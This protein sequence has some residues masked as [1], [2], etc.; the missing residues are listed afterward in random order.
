MSILPLPKSGKIDKIYHIADI[1]IRKGDET[2]NRYEE[3][4][5]IFSKFINQIRK[6]ESES[7]VCIIA[8]DLFHDKIIYGPSGIKLF[9][10]LITGISE[11]MPIYIIS[12]NHDLDP[13]NQFSID[14]I[15]PIINSN[16]WSNVVHL[17][18][19]KH[20][21]AGDIS[22]G[23]VPIKYTIDGNTGLIDPLPDF[24][25]AQK[26]YRINIGL[27][28]GYVQKSIPLSWFPSDY[29]YLILGDL[30]LQIVG[31]GNKIENEI[32]DINSEISIMSKYKKIEGKMLWGY[33]GSIVQQNYGENLLGHGFLV[34][35]LKNETVEGYHINNEY[36]LANI[37]YIDNE[38]CCH[39]SYGLDDR[40]EILEDCIKRNWFPNNIGVRIKGN[41]TDYRE[42][43]DIFKKG[44]ILCKD[45]KVGID[46]IDKSVLTDKFNYE[47]DIN[48]DDLYSRSFWIT[49]IE[50]RLNE[51]NI[52]IKSDWKKYLDKPENLLISTDYPINYKDK[53]KKISDEISNYSTLNSDKLMLQHTQFK[54]LYMKWNYMLCYGENN[55]FDFRKLDNK[56]SA[57]S[58]LNGSGKSAFLE[59]I[60]VSLFG[61]GFPSRSNKN[62]SASII[63]VEKPSN[64]VSDTHIYFMLDDALYSIKRNFTY[65][66]TTKKKIKTKAQ[67][68]YSHM[69]LNLE[70]KGQ[71]V[72][73]KEN[74]NKWILEHLG[75][76]N[77]FL[78]TSIIT[79]TRDN[80]YFDIYS[81][82][83]QMDIIISSL[84]LNIL[85]KYSPIIHTSYLSHKNMLTRLNDIYSV[86]VAELQKIEVTD[87]ELVYSEMQLK[88]DKLS[89][90]E[91]EINNINNNLSV[92]N[93][94]LFNLSL[95]K[96]KDEIKEIDQILPEDYI[97]NKELV[98]KYKTRC[99][100]IEH[101]LNNYN[102][103]SCDKNLYKSY[104]NETI[105]LETNAIIKPENYCSG[106]KLDNNLENE[107]VK[108]IDKSN[109]LIEDLRICVK[110]LNLKSESFNDKIKSLNN[111]YLILTK[112]VNENYKICPNVDILKDSEHNEWNKQKKIFIEK[113][114]CLD[115]L[116]S[117]VCNS[118]EK[119]SN[120][121]KNINQFGIV[122]INNFINECKSW[123]DNYESLDKERI[124]L[125]EKIFDMKI[126]MAKCIFKIRTK[127]L[128][129]ELDLLESELLKIPYIDKNDY[130]KL[131]C[132]KH[133]YLV[134]KYYLS[135]TKSEYYISD[136]LCWLK[137]ESFNDYWSEWSKEIERLKE[138]EC[139]NEIIVDNLNEIKLLLKD[140]LEKSTDNN[141]K[142]SEYEMKLFENEQKIINLKHQ[143]NNFIDKKERYSQSIKYD[144]WLNKLKNN[145]SCCLKIE[146]E[147]ELISLKEIISIENYNNSILNKQKEYLNCVKYYNDYIKLSYLKGEYKDSIDLIDKSCIEYGKS[148]T[149]NDNKVKC[150]IELKILLETISDFKE[151]VNNLEILDR[152]FEFYIESVVSDY[153]LPKILK[154]LN[155]ILG[156][157]TQSHRKIVLSCQKEEK[158]FCWYLLDYNSCDKYKR[159]PMSKVSG[160]QKFACALA[161]RIT[162]GKMRFSH[163]HSTQLFID[164]GFTAC[165]YENLAIVP[166][167]LH[168]FLNNYDSVMIVTHLESL[169][170]NC[171]QKIEISKNNKMSELKY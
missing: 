90:L 126:G 101:E 96:L 21:I 100:I 157:I 138:W 68:L 168:G 43:A 142:L 4:S 152:E 1:H 148:V 144:E 127:V 169:T 105:I 61:T 119:I 170:E 29:D 74:A 143:L 3:Y 14:S 41:K 30:H 36:G 26:E 59:I 163:S 11:N 58:G 98:E 147:K 72:C 88:K 104:L 6:E 134:N 107:L 9:I 161:M 32:I 78:M 64:S 45:Y 158:T 164:E 40:Y 129:N 31:N 123:I 65:Q 140:V 99:A 66:D 62:Y 7:T 130:I 116:E 85:S 17:N 166:E 75:N 8:G 171:D 22:F 46:K 82:D 92:C 67:T 33:P 113:Y 27:F 125:N 53:N 115:N 20:Y 69:T 56:V 44:E 97:Y 84:N 12:G 52:S 87:S 71:I 18:E 51:K 2:T 73:D 93:K 37:H 151:K 39:L 13:R 83:K 145:K 159:I 122:D 165:D 154:F 160:Y 15:M 79:Q 155:K 35:D 139:K 81:S 131:I 38:W 135:T 49:S 118:E 111:D 132:L 24:P 110:D 60:A 63:N 76:L 114:I 141:K 136:Y 57:I 55:Y 70:S 86:K 19:L 146:L 149:Y 77:E 103:I 47:T 112:E 117:K 150:D 34:W 108:E 109:L 94:D 28:H 121:I 89:E 91:K 10:D 95:E 42:L 25:K 54:L 156:Y 153:V 133:E 16:L 80:D 106:L 162:L 50:K 23:V 48:F 5:K 167:L 102:E 124:L 128:K 120:W 137:L